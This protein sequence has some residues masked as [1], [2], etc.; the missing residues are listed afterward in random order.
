MIKQFNTL[1]MEFEI[2]DG[3]DGRN[4]TDQDW[5]LVDTKSRDIEGRRPLSQGM[6]G[7]HL[8][9]RKALEGVAVWR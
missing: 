2:L 8:S 6:I 5:M 7:C 3:V 1:D 9:H 4:L